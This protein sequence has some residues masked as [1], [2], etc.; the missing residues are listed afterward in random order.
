MPDFLPI[1]DPSSFLPLISADRALAEG[2]DQ[3]PLPPFDPESIFLLHHAGIRQAVYEGTLILD[4]LC[5]KPHSQSEH[6]PP[7]LL[8]RHA[9]DLGDS[10]ATLLRFGSASDAAILLRSL[11]ESVIC[12]EFMLKDNLLHLEQ[13][14]CY[15]VCFRIKQYETYMKHDPSTAQG[16]KF[17]DLLDSDSAL[18]MAQFPRSD[19]SKERKALEEYLSNPRFKPI[20]ERYNNAKKNKQKRE[21]YSLCSK[22]RNIRELA[23]EIGREAE[24]SMMYQDLSEL[25]SKLNY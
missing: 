16:Q 19:H 17:H 9:L 3:I 4:R 20:W 14:R 13:A 11:L 22:A 25:G 23:K 1:S 8:Y 21:W 6:F 5:D 2:A 10:I 15:W 24:Y 7:T 12:L 18:K